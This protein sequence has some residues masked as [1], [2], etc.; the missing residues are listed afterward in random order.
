MRLL[1]AEDVQ[2]LNLSQ[3]ASRIEAGVAKI[4]FPEAFAVLFPDEP[5]PTYSIH[6]DDD[7]RSYAIE[8]PQ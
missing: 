7:G 3:N 5:T 1:G 2:F 8:E 4:I 6:V